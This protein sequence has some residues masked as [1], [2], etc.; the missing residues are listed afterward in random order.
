MSI[1]QHISVIARINN[2][3]IA[4][5]GFGTI[6]I[7][8]YT[9]LFADMTRTYRRVADMI[10][11]GFA[12][13]GPEVTNA[14]KA[15]GQ[16][17]HAPLIKVLRFTHK[18]TQ[19]FELVVLDAVEGA[20]YKALVGGQGV[21][22]TTISYTADNDDTEDDIAAAL[23]TQLQAVVG[24]NYTATVD[25][26]DLSLINVVGN[27]AANWF[28]IEVQCS[29]ELL[30]IAQTH[31]DPGIATDLAAVKNVDNDWYY[32]A[33][34]FN[35]EAMILEAAEW[36]EGEDFK[37]YIVASSD[38]LI[39]NDALPATDVAAQ[40]K[41]LG[42]KRTLYSYSRKPQLMLGA[43]MEG[44][45]APFNVGTWTAEYMTV[46]GV[47]ADAFSAQQMAVLDSKLC[48]YYKVEANSSIFWP[49]KVAN[50]EY[51]Y[52]DVTVSLD[53]V[54]DLIQKRLFSVRR[55]LANMGSKVG[56][57]DEDIQG[58]LQPAGQGA[59]DIAKSDT[60][61]IVAPGTPGDAN[62]PQPTFTF[63]LVKDIAP[64]ER[65]VRNLPDGSASFRLQGA[66]DT[67]GVDLTVT[68]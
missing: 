56:Y 4:K 49:G 40:L 59:L 35:S 24:R 51:G 44:R 19:Q 36:I 50:T 16:S 14:N 67:I 64:G 34:A 63:P 32:L 8:S 3:G 26:S 37:A 57:T 2:Q 27:A 47:T 43:A 28:W 41:A 1:D 61:K 53:F 20:V 10:A 12:A 42:Y 55:A 5:Q 48:S 13:D 30:G 15:L 62:D 45:L 29:T 38:S 22:E 58:V 68:F 39:E 21:T 66:V 60:H 31:A 65:S 11:A 52:F 7:A 6:G 9:T 46:T 17:P 23:R 18:P 25:A 54:I 33:T